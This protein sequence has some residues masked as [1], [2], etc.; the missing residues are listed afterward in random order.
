[1][2]GIEKMEYIIVLIFMAIGF[3]FGKLVMNQSVK[4]YDRNI[5]LLALFFFIFG[6]ETVIFSAVGFKLTLQNLVSPFLIGVVIRRYVYSFK[7]SY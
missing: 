1:M 3:I 5:I 4:N 2:K 6:S 7:G